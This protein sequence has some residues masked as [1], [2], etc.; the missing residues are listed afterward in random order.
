MTGGAGLYL[1][2]MKFVLLPV[3]QPGAFDSAFSHVA[4]CITEESVSLVREARKS[5]A[6]FFGT[7]SATWGAMT[8]RGSLYGIALEHPVEEHDQLFEEADKSEGAVEISE[9]VFDS[10]TEANGAHSLD[11]AGFSVSTDGV[12]FVGYAKHHDG[13]LEGRTTLESLFFDAVK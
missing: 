7:Y 4:L 1:P 10:L 11:C 5:V 13:E 3:T 2:F 6:Q 8:V 12:D 9:A